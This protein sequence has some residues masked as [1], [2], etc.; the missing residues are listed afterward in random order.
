[1]KLS[2]W[3]DIANLNIILPLMFYMEFIKNLSRM[4]F[5]YPIFNCIVSNMLPVPPGDN[6]TTTHFPS[7]KL[8]SVHLPQYYN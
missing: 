8:S 3:H 6:T 2:T 5:K 4:N 1:M 7:T